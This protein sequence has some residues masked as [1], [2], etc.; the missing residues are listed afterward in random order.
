MSTI[1]IPV[2]YDKWVFK[3]LK[4]I[5]RIPKRT[6]VTLEYDIDENIDDYNVN[7]K[8]KI[9]KKLDEA[10]ELEQQWKLNWESLQSSYIKWTNDLNFIKI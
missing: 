1:T 7:S 6:Y 5:K 8:D 9:S 10:L 2:K 4:T 3:P